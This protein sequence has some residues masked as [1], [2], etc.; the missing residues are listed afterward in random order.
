MTIVKT[1][2]HGEDAYFKM[3]KRKQG[4]NI[5]SKGLRPL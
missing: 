5:D 2:R 1:C 4:R 3:K